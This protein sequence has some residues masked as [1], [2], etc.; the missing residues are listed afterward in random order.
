MSCKQF[1]WFS[2]QNVPPTKKLKRKKK[3]KKKRP[4]SDH[5]QSQLFLFSFRGEIAAVGKIKKFTAYFT[6]ESFEELFS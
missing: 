6:D 1:V 3:K 2:L 5:S 4:S